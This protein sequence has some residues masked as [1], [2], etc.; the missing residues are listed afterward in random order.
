MLM[1]M[2]SY[3]TGNKLA[4]NVTNM[5]AEE[6]KKTIESRQHESTLEENRIAG[7]LSYVWV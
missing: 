6:R 5:Q 7:G 4:Y 3:G 1:V 2:M